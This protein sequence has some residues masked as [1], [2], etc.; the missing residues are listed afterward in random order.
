MT[1][2]L[3]DGPVR[4]WCLGLGT[5]PLTFAIDLLAVVVIDAPLF[6]ELFGR[7]TD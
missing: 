7:A 3:A 1:G 2:G 4:A 5:D 6:D